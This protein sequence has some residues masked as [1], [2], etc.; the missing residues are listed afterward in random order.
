MLS[1][2]IQDMKHKVEIKILGIFIISQI[3]GK[4]GVFTGIHETNED[5]L[6]VIGFVL[7]YLF[8]PIGILNNGETYAAKLFNLMKRKLDNAKSCLL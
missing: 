2:S 6:F 5:K 4:N 8:T 1:W 3:P 7:K